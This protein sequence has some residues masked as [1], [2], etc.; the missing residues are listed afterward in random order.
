MGAVSS[1]GLEGVKNQQGDEKEG[2]EFGITTLAGTELA[3]D[4]AELSGA[5]TLCELFE[6]NAWTA[7]AVR[8]LIKGFRGDAA[9]GFDRLPGWLGRAGFLLHPD[10]KTNSL[11]FRKRK[12]CAVFPTS[13]RNPISP[14]KN[15]L[16]SASNDHWN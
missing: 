13:C 5:E 8:A 14:M 9:A 2:A 10:L 15:V 6:E 12:I 11:T 1:I 7:Q 16:K 3:E 4:P